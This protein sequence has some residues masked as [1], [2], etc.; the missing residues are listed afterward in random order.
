MPLHYFAKMN[1]KF[2]NIINK[3]GEAIYFGSIYT[4]ELIHEIFEELSNNISWSNETIIMFGKEITTK[5][6]VA[7][8]ANNGISYTYSQ[9]TKNI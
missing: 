1:N 2:P 8:Y 4:D 9:K 7:F 6:K 3:D 5:R